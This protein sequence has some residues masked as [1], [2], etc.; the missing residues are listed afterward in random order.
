VVGALEAPRTIE[1]AGHHHG[2][3]VDEPAQKEQT[4]APDGEAPGCP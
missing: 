3:G 2:V 4:G 1:K